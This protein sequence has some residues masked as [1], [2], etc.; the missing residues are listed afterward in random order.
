[1]F[2]WRGRK[3]GGFIAGVIGG[4]AGCTVLPLFN[5]MLLL[6]DEWGTPALKCKT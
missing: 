5:C 6:A 4:R 2:D 3:G 1:M